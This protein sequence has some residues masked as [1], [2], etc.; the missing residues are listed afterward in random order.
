MPRVLR[1]GSWVGGDMDGN[2]N[3]GAE[4]IAATLKSQR[5]RILERY[6]AEV[7]ELS[8]LLSQTAD[9]VDVA[10][11]LMRRIEAYKTLLPKAAAA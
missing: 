6:A 5:E 7:G 9:L 10:A 8:G 1:F 2:P 3:V 11:E 4:T